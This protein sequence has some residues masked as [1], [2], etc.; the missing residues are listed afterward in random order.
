VIDCLRDLLGDKCRVGA[1]TGSAAS[2]VQGTTV[3]QLLNIRVTK[4]KTKRIFSESKL[5]EMQQKWEHIDYLIIDEVSLISQNMMML[6]DRNLKQFKTRH[7]Q[8]PFGGM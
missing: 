6:I 2:N 1:Y 4:T 7:T 3:H 8:A 5:M